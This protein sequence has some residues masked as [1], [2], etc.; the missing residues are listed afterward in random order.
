MNRK[1]VQLGWLAVY[2]L[3]KTLGG[4]LLAVKT[5]CVIVD[6]PINVNTS[7]TRGGYKIEKISEKSLRNFMTRQHNHTV[8]DVATFDLNLKDIVKVDIKD[9]YD[10]EAIVNTILDNDNVLLL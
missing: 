10:T 6:S 7:D 3:I 4:T 1:I 9:E 5:D 8:R 2:K